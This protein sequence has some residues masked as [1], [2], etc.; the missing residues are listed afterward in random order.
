MLL[1]DIEKS[2]IATITAS[3]ETA[4]VTLQSEIVPMC[5][6]DIDFLQSPFNG[7]RA[8]SFC[9]M[10]LIRDDENVIIFA[11]STATCNL[12]ILYDFKPYIWVNVTIVKMKLPNLGTYHVAFSFDDVST[13]N[14]RSEF[15]VWLG[16]TGI[17]TFGDS[18]VPQDVFVRDLS[19]S[20]VGLMGPNDLSLARYIPIHLQFRYSLTQQS[21]PKLYTID[22]S[23][24]RWTPI[25]SNKYLIGCHMKSQ[26]KDLTRMLYAKQ[27][28]DLKYEQEH[29]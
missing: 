24:V 22:T 1:N 13:F 10:H 3:N 4:S 19:P 26:N 23:I 16:C 2:T 7:K 17:A 14:R 27:R 6:E 12:T 29:A 5:Q 20:G 15:R 25:N 9:A 11:N 18:Q 8:P 21:D 28:Q